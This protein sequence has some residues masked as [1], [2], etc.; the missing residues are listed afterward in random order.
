MTVLPGGRR[1]PAAASLV[2][3]ALA[4]IVAACSG[5]SSRTVT[6]EAPSNGATGSASKQSAPSPQPAASERLNVYA[7][8]GA[9]RLSVAARAAKPLVYVPETISG[10]VRVIDPRTF[11]VVG[12]YRTGNLT[13]HVVPSWDM[14]TLW[15]TASTP[16]R[17]IGFDPRTGR[18]S[19]RIVHVQNPYNLYFTPDGHYAMA[20]DEDHRTVHWLLTSTM[21]EVDAMPIPRCS[22]LDHTDFSADGRT[23]LS[24][25][26]FSGQGGR[27]AVLAVI[28]VADQTVRGYV[29]LGRGAMP[30]DIKLSPDGRHYYVADMMNGGI[31]IVDATKLKVTGFVRTG[32]EAHGLYFSRDARRLFVTNRGE[33]SVS[34]LD[35]ATAKTITKWHIPGGGSPDMGN[36]TADGKQLWLSG[37][38]D[39]VV[40]ALDT[41]TGRLLAKIPVGLGPHGLCV[42][43]QPGRYSVGHTG[44]TR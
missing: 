35:A 28:G 4:L 37:R 19:G 24:T 38:Y 1:R 26:E 39:G 34:V 21:R 29:T 40:Y 43:P 44:I 32:K 8:A 2:A 23:A 20:I 15:A 25:C 18:P 12:T 7:A 5:Q 10:D 16:D 27:D 41:S 31:W 14:R 11:R 22:G 42:W 6:P 36:I 3:A 30:Q 9:G 33:G 17:L 13:Q